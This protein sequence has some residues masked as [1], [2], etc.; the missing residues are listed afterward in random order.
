[1][2]DA[3]KDVCE[4]EA[5]KK[6]RDERLASMRQQIEEL[7]VKLLQTEKQEKKLIVDN[8]MIGD[9]LKEI[10]HSYFRCKDNLITANNARKEAET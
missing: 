1:M 6:D 9:E 2:N 4:I 10:K 3:M 7:E 8:R 5:F